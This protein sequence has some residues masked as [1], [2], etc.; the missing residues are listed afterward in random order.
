MKSMMKLSEDN[1]FSLESAIGKTGEVYLTIPAEK[2][3]KG[4]VFVS[5]KG[6]TRELAAVTNSENEIK[7]GTLVK[8]TALEGDLLVV[9]P[10]S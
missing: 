3:G 9:E 10:F 5:V 6:S 8:I 4:K 7:R 2:K 1:T